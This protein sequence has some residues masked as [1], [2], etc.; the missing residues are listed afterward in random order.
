VV[1]SPKSRPPRTSLGHIA[2]Q[3]GNPP[4]ASRIRADIVHSSHYTAGVTRSIFGDVSLNC[5]AD[6]YPASRKLPPR[7]ILAG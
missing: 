6:F 4:G 3:V 7:I 1:I 5:D 2:P